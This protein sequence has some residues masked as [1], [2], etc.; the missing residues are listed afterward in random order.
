MVSSTL[1]PLLYDLKLP[2]V[3]S[4][5]VASCEI[6][7]RRLWAG[8]RNWAL[9]LALWRLWLVMASQR[10]RTHKCT[11][12][13]TQ[14]LGENSILRNTAQHNYCIIKTVRLVFME[15][16]HV[17]AP[18]TQTK[19]KISCACHWLLCHGWRPP[20][21]SLCPLL[22]VVSVVPC[23]FRSPWPCGVTPGSAAARFLGLRVRILPRT[24]IF[25][26]WFCCVA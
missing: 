25:V 3:R 10:A 12:A 21:R 20:P 14:I 8:W 16:L 26:S 1:T 2:T 6:L 19:K 11:H 23:W 18:Y 5:V 24:W 15:L 9:A 4:T 7:R 17:S 13:R 22:I